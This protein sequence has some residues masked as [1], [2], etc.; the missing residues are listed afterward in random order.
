MAAMT[1]KAIGP[2]SPIH[3]SKIN[4]IMGNLLRNMQAKREP[5]QE[6]VKNPIP[7]IIVLKPARI[8]PY[9]AVCFPQTEV[10]LRMIR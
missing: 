3:F 7:A 6:S 1:E 4:W 8:T 5:S 9:T 10:P 2:Q